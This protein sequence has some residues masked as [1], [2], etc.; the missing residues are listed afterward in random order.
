MRCNSLCVCPFNIQ[1][2]IVVKGIKGQQAA[3]LT[4]FVGYFLLALSYFSLLLLSALND[5]TGPSA[6]PLART[7]YSYS[8]MY[9]YKYLYY[10]YIYIFICMHIY[11]CVLASGITKPLNTTEPGVSDCP[12]QRCCPAQLGTVF[13]F[14]SPFRSLFAE[15]S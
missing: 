6:R 2:I 12:L 8:I 10:I 15:G 4:N 14:T 13:N 3:A 7:T 11:V 9:V 1:P 5:L